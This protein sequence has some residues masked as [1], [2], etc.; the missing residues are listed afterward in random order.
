MLDPVF[1]PFFKEGFG[2]VF[3]GG[4]LFKSVL[5]IALAFVKL[6]IMTRLISLSFISAVLYISAFPREQ[7]VHS[8][9]LGNTQTFV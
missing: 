4:N 9:L 2:L 5:T 6:V 8:F 1:D 7:L 3:F